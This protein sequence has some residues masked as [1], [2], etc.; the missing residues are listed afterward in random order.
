[1]VDV[2]LDVVSELLGTAGVGI[3]EEAAESICVS[4][5]SV[6]VATTY[7]ST[8]ARTSRIEPLPN[9]SA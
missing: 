3:G 6:P 9:A 5:D 4:R 8:R 7:T 2:V 1:V